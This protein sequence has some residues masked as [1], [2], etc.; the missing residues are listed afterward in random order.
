VENDPKN[1]A[2]EAPEPEDAGTEYEAALAK[3]SDRRRRFVEQYLVDLNATQA[4]IRAEY[5]EKGAHTQGWRLLR[6]V[7][8]A[9]AVRLGLADMAERSH[10]T[11]TWVREGLKQNVRRAWDRDDLTAATTST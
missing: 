8:V 9:N 5:G 2:D 11:Q 4:A 3:L 7:E 10:L 6:N 1:K